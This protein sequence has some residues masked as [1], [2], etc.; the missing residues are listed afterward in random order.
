M[1]RSLAKAH[2]DPALEPRY[3]RKFR[4]ESCSRSVAEHT[5]LR[6]RALF[7]EIFHERYVN[8][9]YYDTTDL[10]LYFQNVDGDAERDKVRIRWYGDLIGTHPNTVLE[11]KRKY[12]LVGTKESTSIGALNFVPGVSGRELV[13]AIDRE[14]VPELLRATSRSLRPVLHVRYRRRYYR[15]V[16]GRF[17]VTIDDKLSFVRL[18]PGFNSLAHRASDSA[19]ILELKYALDDDAAAVAI[20]SALPFRM[21]RNSKYVVGVDKLFAPG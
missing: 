14:G 12:G 1:A 10:R 9:I 8:S 16:C 11:R 7:R 17:R 4:I 3:E 13:A 20:A 21:T 15:T 2:A 19:I 18:V 6:H 5:I